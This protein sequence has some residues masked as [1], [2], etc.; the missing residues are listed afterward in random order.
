MHNGII[1][2][3]TDLGGDLSRG[4]GPEPFQL[5][6][7]GLVYAPAGRLRLLHHHLAPVEPETA[8]PSVD[9]TTGRSS[10]PTQKAWVGGLETAESRGTKIRDT[11]EGRLLLTMLRYCKLPVTIRTGPRR[12]DQLT[13][14]DL[15]SLVNEAA[16]RLG[17][18]QEQVEYWS[19]CLP[20]STVKK[21]VCYVTGS[22]P[23]QLKS[24]PLPAC[25]LPDSPVGGVDEAVLPVG[26]AV[27]LDRL[28][29]PRD[30]AVLQ[31]CEN[32]RREKAN[33]T[34]E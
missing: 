31:H 28:H 12:I 17:R 20:Q 6:R 18:H 25:C 23:R 21:A 9:E 2:L 34:H 11:R 27:V 10:E 13:G 22:L 30:R 3:E 5:G 4:R 7:D 26:G 32:Q 15:R 16:M 24:S 8:G 33:K 1:Q 14:E 19:P 29:L